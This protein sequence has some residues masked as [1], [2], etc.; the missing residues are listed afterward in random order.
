M[1]ELTPLDERVLAALP[2]SGAG[3]RATSLLWPVWLR[4]PGLNGVYEIREVL[5]GLEAIG[6]AV[7]RG[8]WWSRA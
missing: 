3:V 8:G 1:T 2:E 4:S 7:N 5:R 6:L